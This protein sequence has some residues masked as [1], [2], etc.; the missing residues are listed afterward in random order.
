MRVRKENIPVLKLLDELSGVPAAVRMVWQGARGPV[1]ALVGTQVLVG[2]VPVGVAWVTKQVVDS[3]ATGQV[4]THIIRY[5]AIYVALAII[6]ALMGRIAAL[7][8]RIARDQVTHTLRTRVD[9]TMADLDLAFFELPENYDAFARAKREIGLRPFLVINSLVGIVEAAVTVLGYVALISGYRPILLIAFL[10]TI[11]PGLVFQHAGTSQLILTHDKLTPDGRRAT[12]FDEVLTTDTYAKEVRLNGLAPRIL[13]WNTAYT[14]RIL[15]DLR[16]A[17][18]RR[19]RGRAL[20]ALV[21]VA[22]QC[23]A[24]G[25]AILDAAGGRISVGTLTLMIAAFTAVAGAMETIMSSA[26][27]IYEGGLF[28]RSMQTFLTRRP[29]ITTPDHPTATP[30]T[31]THALRFEDVT[32][33]YPGGTHPVLEHFDIELRGGQATA[34]VGENGAGKTTIVKLLCRLY[35]PDDGRITLDGHDIRDF[36]PDEYRARISTILQD[37]ARYQLTLLENVDTVGATEVT[38]RDRDAAA[39]AGI[40]DIIDD[41]DDGWHGALGKQFDPHGTEL[42]GGQ[43]QR[44]ALARALAKDAPI[45]ILD[46]PTSALDAEAEDRVFAQYRSFTTGRTTLLISHRLGTVRRAERILVLDHGR[47]VEDGTHTRLLA[48]DG[49]YARLFRLQAS[50]Y[51]QDEPDP[52]PT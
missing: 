18:Y 2:L 9:E 22:T 48:A 11:I 6:G 28:F 30:H 13:G 24:V 26:S 8:T 35:D 50:G 27:D 41:L 43:W 12:Y 49:T 42:S 46:E 52:E 4:G 19:E 25:W 15:R 47:I 44:I 51:N 45:V 38:D 16:T 14:R 39:K 32:F 7:A 20:A 3:V 17:A 37:F 23:F 5:V 36:D 33:T 40:E 21:T 29:T 10:V 1:M 31:V 34:L